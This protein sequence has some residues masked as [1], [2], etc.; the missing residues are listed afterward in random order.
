[1]RRYSDGQI[2]LIDFGLSRY[3]TDEDMAEG[4][5]PIGL[6]TKG[7]APVEQLEY[8]NRKANFKATIDVYALGATFY[9]L[10]TGESPCLQKC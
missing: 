9:K 8:R 4:E 7:Y 6:G 10:L 1:M 3:F 2:I 5:S